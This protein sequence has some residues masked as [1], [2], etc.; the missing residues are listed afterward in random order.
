MIR[1]T[2]GVWFNHLDSSPDAHGAAN[3]NAP[4]P[5]LPLRKRLP[6]VTPAMTVAHRL[7]RLV[8]A[9]FARRPFALQRLRWPNPFVPPY[10]RREINLYRPGELGDVLMCLAVIR[11]IRERNPTAQITLVTHF[12]ELLAGHPLIDRV[13]AYD[14]P[15]VKR[16]RNVV[17]LRYEVFIPLQ[18]HAIDYLAGS[19]GLR[20]VPH[21]IPL[22]DFSADLGGLRERLPGRRPRIALCRHAGPHTPNKDWPGERW[23]ALIA[24]L[25]PAASIV[26]LGAERGPTTVADDRYIDLRGQTNLRQFCAIIADCDLVISPVTASVHIAAA[27]NT[28]TLSILGGY[29]L[30]STASYPNHTTLYN[31]VAC[32]PCWLRTP[33]P[34]DR[35]CLRGISVDDA[36]AAAR[37]ILSNRPIRAG[38]S[39]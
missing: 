29:E 7:R 31:A 38:H 15:E 8:A 17:S 26:E 36:V 11:A 33:C 10:L 6:N 28:P 22:P 2:S 3:L 37:R 13:L 1:L 27:Y 5:C 35:K 4:C 14:A 24:A 30:P 9:P 25:L 12:H 32:S 34:F 23:D 16:L 39:D 20:N 19:V 18:L 21:V